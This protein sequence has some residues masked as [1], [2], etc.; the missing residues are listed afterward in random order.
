MRVASQAIFGN[1]PPPVQLIA[2]GCPGS[3]KSYILKQFAASEGVKVFR[4]TFHPELSYGDF[5]GA[6]KPV[7]LYVHTLGKTYDADG[8]EIQGM[9][10]NRIPVV[11]YEYR[12]GPFISA[13]TTAKANPEQDVVLLIEEMRVLT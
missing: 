5:V 12:P 7:P 3:G 13:Y 11:K 9:M 1:Q 10:A 8:T 2:M 4:T 6:Y